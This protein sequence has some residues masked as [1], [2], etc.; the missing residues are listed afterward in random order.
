MNCA[1][2]EGYGEIDGVRLTP[3]KPCDCGLDHVILALLE[4]RRVLREAIEAHIRDNAFYERRGYVHLDI[5]R[6]ALSG[7]AQEQT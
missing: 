4:E 1:S 2:T 3:Q 7:A 5:L 6:A